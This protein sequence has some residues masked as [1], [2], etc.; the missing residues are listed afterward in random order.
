[1]FEHNIRKYTMKLK[2]M[3]LVFSMFV[4]SCATTD[5]IEAN[6]TTLAL[7]QGQCVQTINSN[8]PVST[9][10]Y[11]RFNV[12]QNIARLWV[13]QYTSDTFTCNTSGLCASMTGGS[14]YELSGLSTSGSTV[15]GV[16]NKLT[17]V[18]GGVSSELVTNVTYNTSAN[19]KFYYDAADG[20]DYISYVG[21]FGSY[22][23]LTTLADN[24]CPNP[25]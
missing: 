25:L 16:I 23:W 18:D 24:T 11:V 15:T 1:M 17:S 4:F 14:S 12:N 8:L 6:G 21:A 9:P 22:G 5:A 20:L 13:L 3:L 2:S 10:K 7:T 19:F